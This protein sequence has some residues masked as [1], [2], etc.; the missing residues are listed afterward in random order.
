[1]SKVLVLFCILILC[2][3]HSYHPLAKYNFNKGSEFVNDSLNIKIDFFGDIS[4][5][6]L[7]DLEPK[8]V[9]KT[10]RKVEGLKSR[11]LLLAGESVVSPL[12]K[13]YLFHK[14]A[15]DEA[16]EMQAGSTVI[17]QIDSL[18]S[19][20]LFKKSISSDVVYF[21]L[22]PKTASTPLKSLIKDGKYLTERIEQ[23]SEGK[24]HLK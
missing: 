17:M 6:S 11:D 2:S 3:C 5:T 1:M 16:N 8:E 20:I 9:S 10:L 18:N 12:Y 24:T 15:T 7:N 14:P 4:F 21:L 19:N 13:F 23:L 22:K